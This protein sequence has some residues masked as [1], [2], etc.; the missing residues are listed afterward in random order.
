MKREEALGEVMSY[1]NKITNLDTLK[2]FIRQI[3]GEPGYEKIAAYLSSAVKAISQGSEDEEMV[4]EEAEDEMIGPEEFYDPSGK[5]VGPEEYDEVMSSAAQ[6]DEYEGEVETM[7]V[8][9]DGEE[10]EGVLTYTAR[11][12]PATG[13][14]SVN[15]TGG[16]ATGYNTAAKVD[17]YYIDYI[18]NSP[19]YNSDYKAE[20]LEDA[21]LYFNGQEEEEFDAE[22]ADLDNDGELEGWE[23]GIAKKR[24]FTDVPEENEEDA[25]MLG[26]ARSYTSIYLTEQSRKDSFTRASESKGQSFKERYKPKT[27][28]QLDELRRYGL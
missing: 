2:S 27:S 15:L 1:S 25:G 24:G 16:H 17:E 4:D 13:E 8:G 7:W 10:V 26:E 11:R 23:K 20:A 6:G 12:D 21:K 3:A 28:Y 9:D 22:K 5:G 19:Q 18:I 14:I